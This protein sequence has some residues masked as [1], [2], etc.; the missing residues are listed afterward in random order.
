MS[1]CGSGGYYLFKYCV[2]IKNELNDGVS[3]KRILP[4]IK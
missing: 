4:V 2:E 1:F 3:K